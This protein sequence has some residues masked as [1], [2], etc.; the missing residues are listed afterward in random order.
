MRHQRGHASR[1]VVWTGALPVPQLRVRRGFRARSPVVVQF[2][3]IGFGGALREPRTVPHECREFV[4]HHFI[5]LCG[6]PGPRTQEGNPSTQ[7]RRDA[8]ISAER[9]N[10]FS[11][12]LPPR[13]RVKYTTHPQTVFSALISAPLRLCVESH[14]L[15]SPF[16]AE[17]LEVPVVAAHPA[18]QHFEAAQRTIALH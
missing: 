1:D 9:T 16:H 4:V 11:A 15:P 14:L 8:E 12:F 3:R 7:R 5:P 17:P 13:L 2:A 10:A 18:C 6:S